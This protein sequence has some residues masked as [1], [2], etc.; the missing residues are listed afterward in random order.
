[1]L[2]MILMNGS[3]ILLVSGAA[4]FGTMIGGVNGVNGVY[5]FLMNNLNLFTCL[6]YVI[7]GSVYSAVVLFCVCR[8]CRSARFVMLRQKT[9]SVLFCLAFYL[10]FCSGTCCFPAHDAD[11]V[12]APS[13]IEDYTELVETAGVNEYS[14]VWVIGT[15][16]LPPLVEEII[17]RG[18]ISVI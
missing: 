2:T 12:I 16:I 11:N 8:A 7:T 6:I 14:P 17:F 18:L 4:F 3:G 9:E 1:M 10:E 15:L 13:A 5:E